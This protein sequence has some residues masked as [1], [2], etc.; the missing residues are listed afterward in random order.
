MV[1]RLLVLRESATSRHSSPQR[2]GYAHCT[3]TYV[4]TH[5]A[6]YA[7]CQ[8]HRL[9]TLNFQNDNLQSSLPLSSRSRCPGKWARCRGDGPWWTCGSCREGKT[10]CPCS[11]RMWAAGKQTGSSMTVR[12]PQGNKAGRDGG[13]RG[14]TLHGQGLRNAVTIC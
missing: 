6:R 2:C 12:W 4:F 13:G 9:G 5:L 14:A 10:S 8:N 7:R 1:A 3:G 11:S